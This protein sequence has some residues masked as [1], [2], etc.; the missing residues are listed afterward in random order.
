MILYREERSGGGDEKLSPSV[1]VSV[2]SANTLS[3]L[4]SRASPDN[5]SRKYLESR[6]MVSDLP[7][8][9]NKTTLLTRH[10]FLWQHFKSI[11]TVTPCHLIRIETS[12]VIG[13]FYIHSCIIVNKIYN[14]FLANCQPTFILET[15]Y[16]LG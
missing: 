15:I 2:F 3:N 4:Q 8:R 1:T 6:T 13:D 11:A 9:I 10:L 14:Y 5:T 12:L 7:T 16:S